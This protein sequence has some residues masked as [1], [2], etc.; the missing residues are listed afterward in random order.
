MI[1]TRAKKK[2]IKKI[3]NEESFILRVSLFNGLLSSKLPL[4]TSTT[5]S[6][7]YMIT[8]PSIYIYSSL[9][10]NLKMSGLL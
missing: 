10:V 4:N 9:T 5:E 7:C 8:M 2:Y 1:K 3:K 6:R